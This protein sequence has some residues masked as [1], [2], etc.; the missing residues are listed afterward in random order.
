MLSQKL[1]IVSM[2]IGAAVAGVI[3]HP[4]DTP[5]TNLLAKDSYDTS[6][7]GSDLCDM[8]EN[9]KRSTTN[10]LAKDSYDTSDWESDMSDLE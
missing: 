6:D 4:R 3:T 5:K 2:A 10:S 9:I 8:E 7:W 1:L